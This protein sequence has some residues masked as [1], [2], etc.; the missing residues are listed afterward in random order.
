MF[1][2]EQIRKLRPGLQFDELVRKLTSTVPLDPSYENSDAFGA[3][4]N[5]CE[6]HKAHWDLHSADKDGK[7][8]CDIYCRLNE[9]G[10]HELGSTVSLAICRAI[11]IAAMRWGLL[12]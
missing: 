7:Y 2:A 5:F 6:I 8:R 10:D 9:G 3:L 12:E 11:V 1:T 4:I